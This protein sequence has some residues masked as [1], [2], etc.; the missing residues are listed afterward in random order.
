VIGLCAHRAHLSRLWLEIG[1]CVCT[2]A[3]LGLHAGLEEDDRATWSTLSRLHATVGPVGVVSRNRVDN[4][5]AY[6]ERYGFVEKRRS[7]RD[8]RVTLLTP[9]ERLT[10]VDAAFLGVL[11]RAA[12]L[13]RG[14][15]DR[16]APALRPARHLAIR[17]EMMMRLRLWPR[18]MRRHRDLMPFLER[19]SGCLILLLLLQGAG[20]PDRLD[21]CLRYDTGAELASVS[22][23]HV[24][25]LIEEA[26]RAGL[27]EI[28]EPGGRHIRLS[29]RLWQAA[30]RWFADCLDFFHACDRR[31]RSAETAG[32][33]EGPDGGG[34]T[35]TDAVAGLSVRRGASRGALGA[36]AC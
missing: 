3:I 21:T 30:D 19:D 8:R 7:A 22:R 29:P 5:V 17:R 6:L 2:T 18:A 23:T 12:R 13:M 33:P 24:R 26:E 15:D 4:F 34:D 31:A 11:D 14:E 28:V 20:A 10:L 16:A 25:M 32:A 27:L 36:R 1:R 9:T 35:F